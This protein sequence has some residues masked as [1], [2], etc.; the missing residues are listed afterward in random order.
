MD[1]YAEIPY[2]RRE[3]FPQ[4]VTTLGDNLVL[5]RSHLILHT[6]FFTTLLSLGLLLL[7]HPPHAIF[8]GPT[9]IGQLWQ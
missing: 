1:G 7:S 9:L 3:L 2:S 6:L 8:T 4:A 5:H